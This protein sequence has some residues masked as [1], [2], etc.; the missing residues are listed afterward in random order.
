MQGLEPIT[1]YILAKQRASLFADETKVQQAL[2]CPKGSFRRERWVPVRMQQQAREIIS[3]LLKSK[4]C[5]Y[6]LYGVVAV[7]LRLHTALFM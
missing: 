4:G 7:E 3:T 5:V 1:T 6:I 2:G